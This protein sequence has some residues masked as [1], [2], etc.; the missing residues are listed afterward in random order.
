MSANDD[1]VWVSG[2]GLLYTKPVKLP[3]NLFSFL[4]PL[5]LE[6]WIYIALAYM[7]VSIL[8]FLLAR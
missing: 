5:S 6:V 3:P 7:G 1:A 4:S 2:I 8:M